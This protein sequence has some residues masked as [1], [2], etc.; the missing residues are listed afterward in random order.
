MQ[1]HLLGASP[2]YESIGAVAVWSR[3]SARRDAGLYACNSLGNI[4]EG[5]TEGAG[6]SGGCLVFQSVALCCLTL[7]GSQLF[8]VRACSHCVGGWSPSLASVSALS[9]SGIPQCAGVH[10][11]LMCHPVFSSWSM[12]VRVFLATSQLPLWSVFRVGWL[13]SLNP[14][15][16]RRAVLEGS[17]SRNLRGF[18]GLSAC[19]PSSASAVSSTFRMVTGK[20]GPRLSCP[21]ASLEFRL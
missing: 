5:A 11:T 4:V 17:C 8:V 14:S 19:G 7:A 13:S 2:G 9:F 6:R 20:G 3:N 10:S 1:E 12:M 16:Y 15:V 18:V 21:P